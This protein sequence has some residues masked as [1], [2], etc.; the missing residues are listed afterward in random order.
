[1]TWIMKDEQDV[2]SPD[3]RAQWEVTPALESVISQTAVR[4]GN[5]APLLT[6]GLAFGAYALVFYASALLLFAQT[7][8]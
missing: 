6:T 8:F 7:G 5:R 4:R 1:M 3:L 2:V